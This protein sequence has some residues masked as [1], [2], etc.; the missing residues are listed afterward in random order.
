MLDDFDRP[1]LSRRGIETID[2]DIGLILARTTV[3]HLASEIA[4]RA[5]QWQP[6]VLGRSVMIAPDFGWVFRLAGHEW[7]IF[8]H[9]AYHL[10]G[11]PAEL[12]T[13]LSVPVVAYD[14]SD[15][16]G[17]IGYVFAERG[18]VRESL[19]LVDGE[20]EFSSEIRP[21]LRP[22]DGYETVRQFFQEHDAYE[23]G[24]V[25]NY[26]FADSS[27][28]PRL[29]PGDERLVGNPGFTLCSEAGEVTTVPTFERVDYI[30]LG[31]T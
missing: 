2:R 28:I 1:W 23:P 25:V 9:D 29:V 24:I 20:L 3:E 19:S 13:C 15:T 18:A 5:T 11:S 7:A 27:T 17:S 16:T 26:F 14:C 6:N 30:V 12:S 4:S 21:D 10:A 22:D 31:R 8:L